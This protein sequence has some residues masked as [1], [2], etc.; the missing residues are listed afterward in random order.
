MTNELATRASTAGLVSLDDPACETPALA[1]NKASTLALLRRA[2]FQVPSGVVVPADALGGVD[3]EL[4][5]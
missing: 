1:G 2:G 5:A 3:L 4:P